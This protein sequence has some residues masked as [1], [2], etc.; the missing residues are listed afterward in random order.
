MVAAV[1]GELQRFAIGSPC[2]QRP[3]VYMF[4]EPSSVSRCQAASQCGAN[5][6]FA[7]RL[8]HVRHCGRARSVGARLPFGLHL[9]PLRCSSVYGVVTVPSPVRDGINIFLDGYIPAENMLFREESLTFKIA[10]TAEDEVLDRK[11][12][13]VCPP[14]TKT[15]GNFSLSVEGGEFSR[16]RDHSCSSARTVRVRRRLSRCWRA[17]WSRIR[18]PRSRRSSTCRSSRRRSRPSSQGTVRMLLLKQIKSAFMHPQ[19][20]TD[21]VKPMSIEP[22]I[23]NDVQTLSGGELQ[24]VALVLGLGKPRTST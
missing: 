3:N 6:P 17:S 2:I 11:P 15:L 13:Y 10:E 22:I 19:F 5:D 23:D 14:M 4:D 24:R 8:Q 16:F 18:G 1:R 20:Q 21:V 7:P 9:L 12:K